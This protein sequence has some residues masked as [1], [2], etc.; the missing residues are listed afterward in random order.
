M[1]AVTEAMRTM[2]PQEIPFRTEAVFRL[3]KIPPATARARGWWARVEALWSRALRV[4]SPRYHYRIFPLFGEGDEST[5][6]IGDVIF[7]G[8]GVAARLRH[9]H[10][11]AVFLITL[12]GEIDTAIRALQPE[13]SE[14]A[15]FLDA[16]AS[17]LLHGALQILRDDLAEFARRHGSRLTQRFSPGYARWPLSEQTQLFHLLEDGREIGI[18]LTEGLFM[19]PQK[20]L[21]GI[22][23]LQHFS[24]TTEG[25]GACKKPNSMNS[26]A[27]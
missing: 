14:A 13:D 1:E 22:F 25:S 4:I 6:R 16:V 18:R 19:V 15:Y 17:T 7:Q 2:A 10:A 11:A 26:P 24:P 27:R 23:G 20:S 3:L 9:C 5:C 8:R 21:S 12:G